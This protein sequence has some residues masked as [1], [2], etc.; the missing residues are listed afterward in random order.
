MMAKR[1]FL[2]VLDSMGIGEMPD[3]AAFGDSG[4]NTLRSISKSSQ[5]HVPTLQEM[6][7]FNI[8]GVNC[9][10]GSAAPGASYARLAEK[11]MG[12]DTTV[13]HWEITG[14]SSPRALPTYPHGFPDDFLRA[15]EAKVGR[16]TVCNKPYS[17]T[18]VIADYGEHHMKTGDLIVYTSADSVFQ[19]AANEAVVPIPELY[20]IC[21]TARDMLTESG[22]HAVGRVIARPF[23]GTEKSNFARTSNRH[24]YSLEPPRQTLLDYLMKAGQD[25]IGVG[26][27]YDIFSGQG[28]SEQ[29]KTKGNADGMRVTLE[30]SQRDFSGLAF[31]NL[32]DFDMVYGHRNNVDGYAAALTEFDVA[33]ARLLEQLRPQDLLI[34]TADHGCDPGYTKTTDHTR[35]YVPLLIYGQAVQP[36]VNLGTRGTFADIAATIGEYLEVSADIEGESVWSKIKK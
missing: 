22:E 4:A 5:F 23:V 35:E 10:E 18:E 25:T 24:D 6:G 1:V 13:G 9:A 27:I 32:V 2:I 33:L 17:G 19:I 31:I 20:A 21:Q 29:I 26:K 8:E 28:I 14:V 11:S 34:I 36:G 16:K 15:F 12:K 30:L 7:L 3:A